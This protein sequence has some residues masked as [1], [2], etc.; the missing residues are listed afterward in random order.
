MNRPIGIFYAYW[1]HEWDVD[2]LPFIGKVKRR[3]F[4]END[5]KGHPWVG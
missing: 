3:R 4:H 5:V 2:F 1:T